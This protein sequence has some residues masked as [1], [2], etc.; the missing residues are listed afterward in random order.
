MEASRPT[1]ADGGRETTGHMTVVIKAV[2]IG[3]GGCNAVT[4]MVRAGIR[5]IG[6]IAMNTDA[7][8][9]SLAEAPT[10]MQLGAQ[11]TK[12][13]GAGGDPSVGARAA[14]QGREEIRSTIRGADMVFIAAG[15][16]GG[17][18]TGAAPVVAEI[19]RE[20]GALTIAFVTK[21]FSFEGRRRR[22]VAEEGIEKLA[23]RTDTLIVVPNDRA[24]QLCDDRAAASD[25]FKLVDEVFCQAVAAVSEVII[26]PGMINLDFAGVRSIM[27]DAGLAWMSIGVGTGQDRAVD[28]ARNALTSPF[29]EVQV[30]GAKAVLFTITGGS[31]LTL[32]EVNRA[33]QFISQ[34]VD[35]QA[36]IIFGVTID[37]KMQ[38]ELKITLI[39]TR[40]STEPKA[41]Q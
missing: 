5:G 3:G 12:G 35:P 41:H 10:R 32:F 16:G 24:L 33:A 11:I 6:F 25:A 7:Q 40:V 31:D 1:E 2:G 9:L 36:N 18:G 29:L 30:A 19:A 37:P 13:L 22:Q 23:T 39:A 15:M 8:A 38:N 28:A 14:D 27:K 26:V 4:R 21:P 34:A 20:C 17:T